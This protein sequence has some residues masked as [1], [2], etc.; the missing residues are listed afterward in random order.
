MS[1][2][3]QPHPE[4]PGWLRNRHTRATPGPAGRA[5][6]LLD[7]VAGP[8]DRIWPSRW[9]TPI[10]LEH[11]LRIDSRGG[12]GSV[13]YQ[14]VVLVPGRSV[15][16][17][18][19]RGSPLIGRHRLWLEP[20]ADGGVRWV[21]DL[22]FAAPPSRRAHLLQLLVIPLHDGLLEDLLDNAERELGG[23]PRRPGAARLLLRWLDDVVERRPEP[24]ASRDRRRPIAIAT[25]S[26]LGGAA[27]LHVAWGA[28]SAWPARNRAA[29]S[30][31]VVGSDAMPGAVAC[32]VVAAMLSAT[33]AAALARV[34][35]GLDRRHY[36]TG[37]LDVVLR[38][39]AGVLAVRGILGGQAAL[40]GDPAAVAPEFRRADRLV[41]S[42]LCLALAAGLVATTGLRSKRLDRV[43][44][45]RA[46]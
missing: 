5:G 7:G 41:Y 26:A 3:T 13:P 23:R 39:A 31:G 30:R 29:L 46:S 33:A 45:G 24:R 21:H 1:R 18:F 19:T 6:E 32:G 42:P 28:G 34:A 35:P 11:G 14:V 2:F 27:L 12:H 25:A 9:W 40:P 37:P 17:E 10:V 43:F 15:T 22:D 20:L 38:G 4:R 44:R 8:D 16:C 36:A